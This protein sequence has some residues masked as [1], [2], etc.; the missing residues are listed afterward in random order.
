MSHKMFP[1]IK[2]RITFAALVVVIAASQTARADDQAD[3]PVSESSNSSIVTGQRVRLTAASNAFTGITAGTVVKAGDDAV[4][5]FDP[6]T[7]SV[8]EL[9][10]SAITR[11]EIGRQYRKTKRGAIIGLVVGALSS[12]LVVSASGNE[13]ICGPLTAPRDCT[14]SE[15]MGITV[16]VSVFYA[17]LGAVLGH[18]KTGE[19]WTDAP[20]SRMKL[21][22]R[23]ARDGGSVRLAYSF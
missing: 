11:V 7:G 18:R 14:G 4:T 21:S 6:K 8:T 19:T 23:P 5:L 10:L 12:A 17:G 13:S 15:K 1:S 3:E 16:G 9:P 2:R 20:V 22:L